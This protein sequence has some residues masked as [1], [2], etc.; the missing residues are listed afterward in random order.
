MAPKKKASSNKPKRPAGLKNAGVLIYLT[1][2]PP[3]LS[4][5][6]TVALNGGTPFS[7]NG[8]NGWTS[9]SNA[10]VSAVKI[11]DVNQTLIAQ[12]PDPNNPLNSMVPT[13]NWEI[14]QMACAPNYDFSVGWNPHADAIVIM[15]QSVSTL[16]LPLPQKPPKRRP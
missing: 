16:H 6:N 5:T 3:P 14:A 2:T 4:T 10:P 12:Y 8:F 11:Y 9:I 7:P 13:G 15:D 1:S